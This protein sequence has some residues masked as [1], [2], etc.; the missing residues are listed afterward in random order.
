MESSPA[1]FNRLLAELVEQGRGDLAAIVPQV[2]RWPA[3]HRTLLPHR[4]LGRALDRS[5]EPMWNDP[6]FPAARFLAVAPL[7]CRI[8]LYRR[9]LSA[10]RRAEPAEAAALLAAVP[11]V[12]LRL[13]AYS[14]HR[15]RGGWLSDLEDLQLAEL[16]GDL[17]AFVHLCAEG[18]QPEAEI[19][20]ETEG[21]WQT[22]N[23][24]E[25]APML[26]AWRQR[27]PG[28]PLTVTG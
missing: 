18:P 9:G 22:E 13:R 14:Y 8:D 7:A 21:V 24:A 6:P 10:L 5:D 27:N 28:M 11:R 17:D 23:A 2:L 26:E 15:E 20:V 1:R 3:H 12:V 4:H 19:R 16:E 25:L